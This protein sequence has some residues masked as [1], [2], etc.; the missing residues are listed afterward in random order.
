MLRELSPI[1]A[2][3]LMDLNAIEPLGM[4]RMDWH[5]ARLYDMVMMQTRTLAS[6]FAGSDGMDDPE[7]GLADWLLENLFITK[8]RTDEDDEQE[9]DLLVATM[10]GI[11]GIRPGMSFEE[12]DLVVSVEE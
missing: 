7:I 1:E 2:R 10:Q 9:L 3:E 8:E 6:A 5:F 12:V 4:D 11:Q